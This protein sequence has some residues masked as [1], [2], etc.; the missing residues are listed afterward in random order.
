MGIDENPNIP[1][2]PPPSEPLEPNSEARNLA[3]LS[4]LLGAL[5]SFLAPLI[6]WLVKKQEHAF[7]DDQ[8]KEA[9]NFQL[10]LL[11]AYA[12]LGAIAV[13]TCGFGAVLFPIPWVFQLVYGIM[14]AMAA[15]RGE[16]Y[17]YP[18]CIRLLN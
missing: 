16:R 5:L 8:G 2:V 17:R 14:G 4:H 10:T 1:A 11:I 7:V 12:I 18:I 13:A 6:I 9:L 15:S 3:M